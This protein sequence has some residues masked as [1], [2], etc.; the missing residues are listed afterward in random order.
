MVPRRIKEPMPLFG[1]PFV[2]IST[3][4]TER[5]TMASARIAIASGPAPR[6][7][8][9]ASINGGPRK[10]RLLTVAVVAWAAAVERSRAATTREVPRTNTKMNRARCEVGGV[11]LGIKRLT[12]WLFRDE[13]QKEGWERKAKREG[14]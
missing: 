1:P 12:K 10:P 11:E 5:R 2:P 4:P 9:K 14:V 3:L 13:A 7:P 6:S 8:K